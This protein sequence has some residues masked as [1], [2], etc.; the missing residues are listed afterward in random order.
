MFS[1]TNQ[2]W[3]TQNSLD[4][5]YLTKNESRQNKPCI[6]LYIHNLLQ[7]KLLSKQNF[8]YKKLTFYI[9]NYSI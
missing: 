7:Y 9:D 6:I 4:T 1:T 8:K 3:N 2:N 5:I